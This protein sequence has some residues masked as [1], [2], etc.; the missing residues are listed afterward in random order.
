VADPELLRGM[1]DVASVLA[2]DEQVLSRPGL[3]DKALTI[4]GPMRMEPAPGPTREQLLA[5]LA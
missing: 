2:T 3:T 5:V 4:G 1:M